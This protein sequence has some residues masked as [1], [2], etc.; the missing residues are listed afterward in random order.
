MENEDKKITCGGCLGKIVMFILALMFMV[1]AKQ[2]GKLIGR[3]VGEQAYS[4]TIYH[5]NG[6][7]SIAYSSMETYDEQFQRII[8]KTVPYLPAR[9]D[10]VTV[11]VACELSPDAYVYKYEIDESVDFST[12]DFNVYDKDVRDRAKSAKN[13]MDLIVDLCS[14]TNRKLCYMYVSKKNGQT[15]ELFIGPEEML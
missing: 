11:W 2:C 6:T 15:H 5:S 12:I 7:G 1:I 14:K 4:S 3:H 9:V 13:D 8:K 10:E